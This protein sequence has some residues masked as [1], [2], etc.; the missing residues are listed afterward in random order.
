MWSNYSELVNKDS[1]SLQFAVARERVNAE[2]EKKMP[3][4]QVMLDHGHDLSCLNH[5]LRAG[6]VFA[7]V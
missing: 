5:R 2:R 1:V 7:N 4:C 6:S 3:I